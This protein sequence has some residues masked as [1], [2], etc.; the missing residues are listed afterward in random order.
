MLW[1]WFPYCFEGVHREL[2]LQRPLL[3]LILKAIAVANLAALISS[4]KTPTTLTPS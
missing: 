4:A 2:A 3:S 1:V